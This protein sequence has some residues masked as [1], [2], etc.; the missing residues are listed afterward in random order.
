MIRF[1]YYKPRTLDEVW[2]L[3]EKVPDAR[4]IAGGTDVM[5]G[6]RNGEMKPS[7]LIS[8]RSIPDL[9]TIE[10]G[11]PTR[12][13]AMVTISTLIQ[14]KALQADFPI[15]VQA[16]RELG[17]VQ[18]RN[19]ATIGGNLCN[20]SPSSD[21]APALLV[22]EA[23]VR[24]QNRQG[25]RIIPLSE[26]FSGP[27]QSCLGP[28][29]ILTDILLE[30]PELETRTAYL[31]KGRMKMDLAI[32]SLAVLLEIKGNTCLKARLAAGSVAPMPVRLT[33][34]EALLEEATLTKNTEDLISQAQEAAMES[35]APITDIRS[36][37]EYRRQIV[38][39]YMKRAL[40]MIIL[41]SQ[42]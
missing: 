41:R 29:E 11:K 32:A 31:K 9:D 36:G 12:I 2:D 26:F 3:K 14:N 16:A 1:L 15:L 27:G 22:L 19:V 38:R 40:Q 13:G 5:V 20:C 8:L 33:K 21:T 24:L 17:C 39:I 23:K 42:S 6:I 28:G 37:E 35:I 4:V 10:V 18:I 34:V 30:P 7:A 25:S